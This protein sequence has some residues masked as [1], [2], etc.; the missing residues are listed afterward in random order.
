M[1]GEFGPREGWPR[2]ILSAAGFHCLQQLTELYHAV[3]DW[4]ELISHENSAPVRARHG[5]GRLVTSQRRRI[6]GHH[7]VHVTL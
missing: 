1:Y 7:R 3:T 5:Y 2:T 6:A 4:A